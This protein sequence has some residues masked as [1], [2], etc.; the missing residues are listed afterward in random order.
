MAILNK[1]DQDSKAFLPRIMTG[2]KTWLYQYYLQDS[3]QT[4]QW[5]PGSGNYHPRSV[6][7]KRRDWSR[8]KVITAVFQDTQGILL[9]DFL[10]G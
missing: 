5:L 4:K 9:I 7:A 2:E 10:E 1:Y 6:K 8:G 3:A